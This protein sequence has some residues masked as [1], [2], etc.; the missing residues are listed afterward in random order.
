MAILIEVVYFYTVVVLKGS[1]IALYLV[2]K[3]CALNEVGEP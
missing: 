2:A 3:A 1:K